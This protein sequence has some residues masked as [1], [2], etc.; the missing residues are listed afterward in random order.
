MD[1][2]TATLLATTLTFTAAD[3]DQT[4][5]IRH[6]PGMY[7]LNPMLGRHP[8]EARVLADGA[9]AA[10]ADVAVAEFLPPL[11]ART[12]LGVACALEVTVVH[13]NAK[14]GLGLRWAA[15]F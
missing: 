10:A 5:K 14:R 7:E 8:S 3:I 2:I 11:Y 13:N 4:L 12:Y 9:L 15:H 6:T 1:P